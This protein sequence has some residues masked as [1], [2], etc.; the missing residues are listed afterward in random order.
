MD[1][2]CDK[3]GDLDEL[4]FS[5]Y[6]IGHSTLVD[7]TETDLE[8]I[9][10]V[11]KIPKNTNNINKNDITTLTNRTDEYVSKYNKIYVQVAK[12]INS[13]IENDNIPD[14]SKCPHGSENS[15]EKSCY[16]KIVGKNYRNIKNGSVMEKDEI[17]DVVNKLGIPEVDSTKPRDDSRKVVLDKENQVIDIRNLDI[18]NADYLTPQSARFVANNIDKKIELGEN[19]PSISE[20]TVDKLLLYYADF[21][22]NDTVINN[23]DFLDY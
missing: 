20:N 19:H 12:V 9:T 2:V 18:I 14:E 11:L 13:I 5:G 8:G 10:F 17:N 15:L 23:S 4:Y 22:D 6:N 21:L 7:P 3:H 1:I 16:P